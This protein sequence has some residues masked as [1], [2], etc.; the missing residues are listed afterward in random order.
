MRLTEKKIEGGKAS[1]LMADDFNPSESLSDKKSI[2][3]GTMHQRNLKLILDSKAKALQNMYFEQT[4][5]NW[6]FISLGK[7]L[8]TDTQTTSEFSKISHQL[9][10]IN[11]VV[12]FHIPGIYLYVISLPNAEIREPWKKGSMEFTFQRE[13]RDKNITKSLEFPSC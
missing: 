10:Q 1:Q 6:K 11:P 3:R 8:K 5:G 2:A 4:L 12:R 9:K 13:A 7:K